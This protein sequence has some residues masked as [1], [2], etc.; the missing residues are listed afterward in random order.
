MV[1]GPTGYNAAAQAQNVA[2]AASVIPAFLC[3]SSPGATKEN[4]LYPA[5]AFGSGFPSVNCTWTGGRTDYGGTTGILSSTNG[6]GWLAYNGSPGG[7][8]H[9]IFRASGINGNITRMR[10][11]TDGTSNTFMFGERTGGLKMYYKTQPATGLAPGIPETNGGS[12][13]DALAFEHWIDGTLYDGT[14]A[15]GPCAMC[16]NLRGRGYHSFHTGGCQFAM[17]DGAVR[18]VSEN[19]AQ[20]VFAGLVTIQKGE[21]LGEF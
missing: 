5:G 13:A 4:Y 1:N 20:S 7:D 3:P 10:D 21:V 2:M 19:V 11:V 12:W 16:T 15:R 9:G 6:F 18:F 14:G 17:A 8:R